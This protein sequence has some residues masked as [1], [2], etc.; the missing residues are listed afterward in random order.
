M[1]P[2]EEMAAWDFLVSF[3]GATTNEKDNGKQVFQKFIPSHCEMQW[4]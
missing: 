2:F 1:F 3:F 4:G